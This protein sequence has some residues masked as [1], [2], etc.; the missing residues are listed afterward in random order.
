MNIPKRLY[1][2]FSPPPLWIVQIGNDELIFSKV[3]QQGIGDQE[4]LYLEPNTVLPNKIANPSSLSRGIKLFCAQKKLIR[5]RA[6]FLLPKDYFP[7]PL[8]AHEL[9]QFLVG[10]KNAPVIP[11]AVMTNPFDKLTTLNTTAI[12][13]I[14][15]TPNHLTMFERYN[16]LHPGWWGVG[17][18]ILLTM[19]VI[20]FTKICTPISNFLE[21]SMPQNLLN[22][23]KKPT[24]PLKKSS[25]PKTAVPS[26]AES[27][28]TLTNIATIIPPTIVLNTLT[29]EKNAKT[30][31][32]SIN[33]VFTGTTCNLQDL[34]E[35]VT[36]LEQHTTKSCNLSY[37]KELSAPESAPSSQFAFYHFSV[38]LE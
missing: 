36:L 14:T 21:P 28:A 18:A 24:Q 17:L 12:Q 26:L 38:S 34:L 15:N 37:I 6:W 20:I 29:L 10:I 35:F 31:N 19:T 16:K 5:F 33:T 2:F 25:S 9:F 30:R 22:T 8:L 1:Y 13:V 7:L 4:R 32:S 11:E 3:T 27:S 23:P